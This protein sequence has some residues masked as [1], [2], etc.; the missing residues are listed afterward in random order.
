M[1]TKRWNSA[2]VPVKG[3]LWVLGGYDGGNMLATS[4][5]VSPDGD[6]SQP[7]PDLPGPRNG[8]CAVKLANGQVM[9]LGGW[10]RESFKSAIIFHPDTGFDQSLPPM[11]FERSS[12]GCATFNSPMHENREVVLAVGGWEQATS[13]HLLIDGA[14]KTGGVEPPWCVYRRT[15]QTPIKGLIVDR[16]RELGEPNRIT[17]QKQQERLKASFMVRSQVCSASIIGRTDC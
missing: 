15:G 1:S 4:E 14:L 17:C 16:Y 6:A 2:S 11:T 3:K 5:Y 8:H 7:G 10:P 12:F 9:L 13:M